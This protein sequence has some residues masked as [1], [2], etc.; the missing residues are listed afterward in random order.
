MT[1]P[2]ILVLDEGTTSTRAMLF[3][4][5]GDLRGMAQ[6]ELTQHYPRPGWVEHD[7]GEIWDKTFVCAREMVEQAGGAERIA[8]IGITNQRETVVAWDR[9]TGKPLARALVWQDR[10]TADF[11]RDFR[12]TRPPRRGARDHRPEARSLFLGHQDALAA[13]PRTAGGG[14]GEGRPA[15]VRNGGKLADL[16]AVRRA[17]QRGRQ[18]QPYP[19]SAA[20]GR[21]LGRRIMRPVRRAARGAARSGRQRR[22]VRHHHAVRRVDS[23]HRR[24]RRP[25]GGDDRPG[26][27]RAWRDQGDLRH[28]GVRPRQHGQRGAALA[29]PPARHRAP[30]TR[31]AALL[32][33][34]R[35]GVRRRQPDP[36]AA[37]FAPD[38]RPCRRDRGARALGRRQRRR[39]RSRRSAALARRTGGRMRGAR[40]AGSASPPPART[41]C[42]PRSKPSPTRRRTSPPLSPPTG[43]HG[44]NSGSTA[45]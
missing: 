38:D 30:P 28:R 25:A 8:A 36:V 11:L 24:R 4:P 18:R 42:A 29:P 5:A 43:P 1:D 14:G 27:P 19:A 40:S 32:R 41:S 20:G 23:D 2:L 44:P 12:R 21:E 37:G 33:A 10:R 7:A 39:G 6:R 15:G 45:G 9:A 17:R 3:T 34:R 35:I 22:F 31:R 13:R 16:Q 26:V